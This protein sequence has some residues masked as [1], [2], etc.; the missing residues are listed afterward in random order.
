MSDTTG[1]ELPAGDD[2]PAG[3]EL[4]AGGEFPAGDDFLSGDS[5]NVVGARGVLAR[6]VGDLV[7]DLGL[8]L[9]RVP[10]R[11]DDL[12]GRLPPRRVLVL[13]IY[14]PTSA[15][16]VTAAGELVD[17]RHEVALALGT[18]GAA[19]TELAADTVAS[20]LRGGKFQNLNAVFQAAGAPREHDWIVV[21]DDDV[22]LPRRFLDRLIA[23][24]EHFD[25][26]LA[27]PAQTLA[28]HAAWGIT[29]RRPRSV[30]RETRFVE[31]G[32]VT[33]F[34]RDAA[35]ELIPFPDLRFGWGLD[36]HW[37][38]LACRRRW[39]LGIADALPVRHESG[40]IAA[41]YAA[42]QAIAEGRRFLADR[43]YLPAGAA[44]ETLVRH[45]RIVVR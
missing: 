35:T 13:S 36:A 5:G 29:R 27:Q 43:P 20:G 42:D 38:A 2:F 24:C 28:S 10:D 40:R 19:H 45:R 16:I 17:S 12:A 1:G 22:R 34:R 7:L 18:T 37:A 9:A 15:E 3:G 11:L 23:L 33:V 8:R 30:L 25:L 41:T 32:P 14:R 39:R 26:A 44:R 21:V 6:R 4:P 31:I